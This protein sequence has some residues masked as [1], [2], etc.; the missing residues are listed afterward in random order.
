VRSHP[1]RLG[2]GQE[3]HVYAE[4]M[5]EALASMDL[6]RSLVSERLVEILADTRA[7]LTHVGPEV[8]DVVDAAAALVS[9]GKRLRAAF[10]TAG[11]CAAGGPPPRHPR[12]PVVG[13]GC[14]LEL[15]QAAA[16][17]H[18]DVMDGSSTRRGRPSAHRRFAGLHE[19]R[20]WLG[21][22]DLFGQAAAILLGDLLLVTSFRELALALHEIPASHSSR[23]QSVYDVMTAEVT[24]GQYL[25]M[26]AQAAPW[27]DRVTHDLD[28]AERV[29]RTKSARYSVEHPIVLGAAMAGGDDRLLADLSAFGLPVG[30]AFQLRD[31]VLGVFGDPEVTGKPAGDDLREGKRTMLLALAME[32]ASEA[33]RRVLRSALG[34][35]DLEPED[36]DAARDVLVRTG[37]LRAVE[38]RIEERALAGR[39]AL[40]AAD[41]DEQVRLQ[42]QTLADRAVDRAA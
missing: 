40:A 6:S 18:D 39:A 20:E 13:A 30:E 36:L 3:G 23:A 11:W 37:A 14:A 35:A 9:G 25:D 16:L 7:R 27:S 38:A 28:R 32:R 31:D 42:L 22:P 8:A 17:V 19:S 12:A 15:F 34:R 29:V 1:A 26:Q 41:I 10:C 2:R 4:R 24:L 33:E 21:S 5:Q